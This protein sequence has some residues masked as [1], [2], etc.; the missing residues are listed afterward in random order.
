M[1]ALK[2]IMTKLIRIEGDLLFVIDNAED[3][4][5]KDKT[6]FRKLVSYFLQLI[7]SMKVLLTSRV[8][9]YYANAE[10]NEENICI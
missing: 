5:Q 8:L 1:K 4:I 6:N 2:L 10:F 9:L 3:M 7:P